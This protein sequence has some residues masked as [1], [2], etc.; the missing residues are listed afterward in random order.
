M[1]RYLEIEEAI[2]MEKDIHLNTKINNMCNVVLYQ[3]NKK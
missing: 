2:Q 1:V 3:T